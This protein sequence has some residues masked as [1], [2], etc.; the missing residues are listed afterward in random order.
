MAPI[1]LYPKMVLLDPWIFSFFVE[2]NRYYRS[3]GV[4]ALL[5]ETSA[6]NFPRNYSSSLNIILREFS[7]VSSLWRRVFNAVYRSSE[8]A[9]SRLIREIR[10]MSSFCIQEWC[11]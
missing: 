5:S 4:E 10:T 7:S 3:P 1:F 9:E 2:G 6:D 8:S 11:F